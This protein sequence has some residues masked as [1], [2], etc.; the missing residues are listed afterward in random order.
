MS[1]ATDVAD[2]DPS[3]N[4]SVHCFL[5]A[6]PSALRSF[7]RFSEEKDHKWKFS[8]S[9]PSPTSPNS[10]GKYIDYTTRDIPAT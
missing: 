1:L 9:L 5:R 8:M 6:S 7:L 2:E 4:L 3:P 10:F